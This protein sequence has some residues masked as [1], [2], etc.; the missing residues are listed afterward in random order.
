MVVHTLEAERLRRARIE[1]QKRYNLT[2]KGRYRQHK[3]NAKRR[4]VPF[5]LTYEQ[6]FELWEPFLG[7][8][9]SWPGGYVMARRGDVGPY[10][11]GNVSIVLHGQNVAERNTVYFTR[12]RWFDPHDDRDYQHVHSAPDIDSARG[13]PGPDVPF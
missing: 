3:R 8:S 12:R 7:K 13:E 2:P 6:W 9:G 4:S 5:L 10:D 1:R 11:I